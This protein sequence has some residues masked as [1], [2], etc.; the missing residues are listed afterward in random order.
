MELRHLVGG[1]ENVT[2][3]VCTSLTLSQ[4]RP[5]VKT[6]IRRFKVLSLAIPFHP[7]NA[8]PLK[9]IGKFFALCQSVYKWKPCIPNW[10]R[11]WST[12]ALPRD[13]IYAAHGTLPYLPLGTDSP[14]NVAPWASFFPAYL[15]FRH[16]ARIVG[17]IYKACWKKRTTGVV[18]RGNVR[19]PFIA[20]AMGRNSGR[21]TRR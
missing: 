2:F 18:Q 6:G 5:T 21:E 11:P 12:F 10:S 1:Y 17:T 3:T 20:Y 8:T 14:E 13:P 15:Q 16:P 7:N 19:Q 9:R 4:I